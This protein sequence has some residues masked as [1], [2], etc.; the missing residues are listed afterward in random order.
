MPSLTWRPDAVVT[1][2]QWRKQCNKC[3][4]YK[5]ERIAKMRIEKEKRS[6]RRRVWHL[7]VLAVRGVLIACSIVVG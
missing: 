4:R 3:S 6:G 7:A 1:G 2:L 5:K